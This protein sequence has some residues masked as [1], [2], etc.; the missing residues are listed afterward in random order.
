MEYHRDTEEEITSIFIELSSFIV[1]AINFTHK[2][3]FCL[4]LRVNI[5]CADNV[6]FS[7]R[8]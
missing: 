2:F 7:E 6:H 1:I 4:R 8:K 3:K 5:R